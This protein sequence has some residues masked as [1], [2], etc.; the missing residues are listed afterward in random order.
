MKINKIDNQKGIKD[1]AVKTVFQGGDWREPNYVELAITNASDL[2]GVK[3]P[4]IGAL[5]DPAPGSI[6]Y[7]PG[8]AEIYQ[9]GRVRRGMDTDIG[10][11][12]C[13]QYLTLPPI[14]LP[15]GNQGEINTNHIKF[16]IGPWQ[17]DYPIGAG[18]IAAIPG[19]SDGLYI[20]YPEAG[21]RSAYPE[22][23]GRAAALVGDD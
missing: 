6:A 19:V 7:T 14:L 15:I 2:V 8:L 16:N 1:M 22:P 12:E 10:G 11:S 9:G 23:L 17:T 18:G 21:K 4:V 5:V 20:I 3:V 13:I